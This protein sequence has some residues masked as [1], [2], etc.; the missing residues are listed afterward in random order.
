MVARPVVF[1]GYTIQVFPEAHFEPSTGLP[2][3]GYDDVPHAQSMKI[4]WGASQGT[5]IF[6]GDWHDFYRPFFL[7]VPDLSLLPNP[8]YLLSAELF[9]VNSPAKRILYSIQRDA[10]GGFG[11][12]R[13][14]SGDYH[15]RAESFWATYHSAREKLNN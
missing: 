14:G 5:V 2:L 15:S 6:P 13:V 3:P 7:E 8:S 9:T 4:C 10:E 12:D 11:I 1:S